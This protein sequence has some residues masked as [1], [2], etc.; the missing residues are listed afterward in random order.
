MSRLSIELTAQQ[1]KQ[2]KALA[3][4]QGLSIRDYVLKNTLP[5]KA[6]RLPMTEKKA[7]EA[8]ET[9]PAPRVEAVRKGRVSRRGVQEVM[10]K[11]RKGL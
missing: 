3:A 10:A 6:P 5:T 4:L 1:H 9:F 7:L 2:I 8:L 11:V